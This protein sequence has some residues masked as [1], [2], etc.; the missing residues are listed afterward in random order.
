MTEEQYIDAKEVY[1]KQLT[2]MMSEIGSISPHLCIFADH[3]NK[4]ILD[5]P[6]VV[7]I[8]I[9]P[10]YMDSEDSKDEFVDEKLPDL[11][12]VLKKDFKPYAIAWTA[13]AWLRVV[14]KDF[15]VE[16]QNWKSVPIKKE[17]VIFSIETENNSET[18]IYNIKRNGK[19]VTKDGDIIDDVALEIDEDLKDTGAS[20]GGRFTGLFRTFKNI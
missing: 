2:H 11:F 19:K 12:K 17:V 14:D 20:A 1:I 5:K 4:E 16:K 13:E 3:L 8:M 10:E 18:I 15:D 6:A 9:P 7:H